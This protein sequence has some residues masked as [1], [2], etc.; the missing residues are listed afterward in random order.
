MTTTMPTRSGAGLGSGDPLA[1]EWDRLYHEHAPRIMRIAA[2]RVGPHL[3][4]DVVQDTLLRVIRNRHSFDTAYSERGW[5][6]T[7]ASRSA[8][9]A[10][11]EKMASLEDL[12]GD[13]IEEQ[14]SPD[15]GEEEFFN[16]VRHKGIDEVLS[17]LNDRHRR[18]LELVIIEG[19]SHEEVAAAMGIKA[20]AVKSLLARA[21]ATFKARYTEF[22]ETSGVFGAGAVG[23]AIWKL[24][25][26]VHRFVEHHAGAVT[27]AV[28][29]VAVVGIAAVPATLVMPTNAYEPTS[30]VSSTQTSGEANPS[31]VGSVAATE[32]AATGSAG[33]TGHSASAASS[34]GTTPEDATQASEPSVSADTTAGRQG[35]GASAG[36]SAENTVPGA[37]GRAY[38]GITVKNC[39]A[40][41][42]TE[43]ECAAIDVLDQMS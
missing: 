10:L 8:I 34:S 14:A 22:S 20:G 2:H 9:D 24:R 30:A 40:N 23:T 25:M 37:E 21:R 27:T 43:V 12:L 19:W 32:A 4:E 41:V 31:A 15:N 17:G 16:A 38:G 6:N 42:G 11:R 26:R 35:Q 7:I 3:A 13:V 1:P 39:D 29:T 28:A 5:I 36:F 18:V 33:G